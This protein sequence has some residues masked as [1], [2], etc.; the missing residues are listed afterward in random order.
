[1]AWVRIPLE[2]YIFILNF[3]LPPRSKQ[4]NGAHANE[5]KHNNSPVV[6]DLSHHTINFDLTILI[7]KFDLLFINFNLGH[8]KFMNRER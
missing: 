2:S 3:S 8:N 4:L 6:I 1:M 5:I 7:L